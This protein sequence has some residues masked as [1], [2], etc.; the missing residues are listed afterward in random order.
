MTRLE[1]PVVVSNAVFAVDWHVETGERV[2]LVPVHG[3]PDR[4]PEEVFEV[5]CQVVPSGPGSSPRTT[6]GCS[7]R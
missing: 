5:P 1:G 3:A 6:S 7:P 4:R 2:D